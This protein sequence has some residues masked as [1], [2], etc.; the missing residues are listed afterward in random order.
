MAQ[1]VTKGK[2]SWLVPILDVAI[3]VIYFI[4]GYSKLFRAFKHMDFVGMFDSVRVAIIF[5][6]IATAVVTVL[7]FL[8]IFKSKLNYRIAVWNVIWM[9]LTIVGLM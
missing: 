8:P 2:L 4:V 6:L 7:C 3:V 9:I 5:L 1:E